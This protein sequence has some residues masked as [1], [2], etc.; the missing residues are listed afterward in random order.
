MW[1]LACEASNAA[2]ALVVAVVAV[3]VVTAAVVNAPI[4][5][6]VPPRAVVVLVLTSAST[7]TAWGLVVFVF[8]A[9]I[10]TF[11][12]GGAVEILE[13]GSHSLEILLSAAA[14]LGLIEKL[15]NVICRGSHLCKGKGCAGADWRE[16][17][18]ARQQPYIGC[19]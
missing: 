5:G 13:G 18:A 1:T 8:V 7:H 15:G 14:L 3:V 10:A 19:G 12:T 11:A 6:V 9:Q 16:R 4:V 17:Y 2:R